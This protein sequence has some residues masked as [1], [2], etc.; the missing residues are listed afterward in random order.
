[1][2]KSV[3]WWIVALVIAG[4][5]VSLWLPIW[6]ASFAWAWSEGV[7]GVSGGL[8]GALF[9]IVATMF[10]IGLAVVAVL[11]AVP[12]ALIA[13]VLGLVLAAIAVVAV[14]GLVALPLLLPLALLLGL[15]WLALRPR[16]APP[17]PALPRPA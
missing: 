8:L 17:V 16:P 9:A 4:W 12:L 5:L 11:L 3:V 1:M 10:A 7:I 6:P 13:T 14:L 15:V 2:S